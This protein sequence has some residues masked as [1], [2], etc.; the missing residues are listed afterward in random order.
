M[1]SYFSFSSK[2]EPEWDNTAFTNLSWISSKAAKT[3]SPAVYLVSYA[4]IS[5]VLLSLIYSSL[6]FI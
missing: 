5:L 3:F 4:Y 6:S 2:N 1:I